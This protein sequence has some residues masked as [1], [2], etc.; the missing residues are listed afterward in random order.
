VEQFILPQ[1]ALVQAAA[2][3]RKGIPIFKAGSWAHLRVVSPTPSSAAGACEA[4]G[5]P[6][7]AQEWREKRRWKARHQGMLSL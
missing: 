7:G 2:R 1:T 5:E 4:A 3:S 6:V